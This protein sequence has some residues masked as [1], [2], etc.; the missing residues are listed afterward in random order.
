VATSEDVV[1]GAA[2]VLLGFLITYLWERRKERV[3]EAQERQRVVVAVWM[4][5][6]DTAVWCR[7]LIKN[8]ESGRTK[9]GF[10][11]HPPRTQAW[12]LAT[13]NWPL[14]R[15]REKEALLLFDISA[16]AEYI[17]A[18]V[19]WRELF[20][21]TNSALSTYGEV[22]ERLNGYLLDRSKK[23]LEKYEKVNSAMEEYL[24]REGLGSLKIADSSVP[25]A[26]TLPEAGHKAT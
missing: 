6:M 9:G 22:I 25:T 12:N 26:N 24:M 19:R 14:L 3:R 18:E 20:Q 13:W 21:A 15:F 16:L 7:E 4:E 5:L 11:L 10:L 17:A 8:M 23:Y 2:L 1:L